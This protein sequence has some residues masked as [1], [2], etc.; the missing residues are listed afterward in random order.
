MEDKIDEMCW[1][2]F[3]LQDT[4]PIEDIMYYVAKYNLHVD[5]KNYSHN[6]TL[7]FRKKGSE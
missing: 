1:L 2:L 7:F 5:F 4:L 6:L 3:N